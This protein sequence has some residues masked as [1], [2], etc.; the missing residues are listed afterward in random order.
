MK[1]VNKNTVWTW[2]AIGKRKGAW[3]LSPNAP[4][5]NKGFLLNHL[6]SD[7]LPKNRDE[8]TIMSNK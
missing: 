2:N 1:G 5:S 8:K 3:N 6:I 4:E 7:V